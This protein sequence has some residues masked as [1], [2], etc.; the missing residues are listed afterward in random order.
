M[1]EQQLGLSDHFA[2]ATAFY[3][4]H[5]ENTKNRI[6]LSKQASNALLDTL[7][8]VHLAS[9]CCC[10]RYS[11]AVGPSVSTANTSGH[12]KTVLGDYG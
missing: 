8:D 3:I 2:K 7:Q 10:R 9:S 12:L 1:E 11:L 4:F 5:L 6:Q